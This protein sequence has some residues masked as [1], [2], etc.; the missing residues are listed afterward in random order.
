MCLGLEIFKNVGVIF[1]LGII[2]WLRF[3]VGLGYLMIIVF[4]FGILL[5]IIECWVILSVG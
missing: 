2:E 1:C 5:R 3:C 4:G